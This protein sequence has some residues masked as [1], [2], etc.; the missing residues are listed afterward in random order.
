[1]KFY[2]VRRV[3]DASPERVWAV[4][5]DARG[6]QEAKLGIT[7]IE[8]ELKAQGQF[9]LWTEVSP[10]RAFSLRVAEWDA[11]RRMVWTSGMPLGLFRGTRT[12]TLQ[13]I[14]GGA[15]TEFHMREEFTGLML[16]MIWKSMPDL[17]PS[18]ERFADGVGAMARSTVAEEHA[19]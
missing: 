14:D 11:P 3:F 12:F 8:G 9:K 16:G 4:L 6:L 18:F 1:M 5:T 10:G 15:R 7:R 19:R 2:E 13:A 17:Q